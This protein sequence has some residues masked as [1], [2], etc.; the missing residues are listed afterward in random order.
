MTPGSN[1]TWN[2][3]GD[4][5]CRFS[6]FC[7]LLGKPFADWMMPIAILLLHQHKTIFVLLASTTHIKWLK[8]TPKCWSPIQ[9]RNEDITLDSSVDT[10]AVQFQWLESGT[11]R[12]HAF[13][14]NLPSFSLVPSQKYG[15]SASLPDSILSTNEG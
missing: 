3:V 13:G 12:Q 11:D 2:S 14:K 15:V 5:F 4:P 9:S 10:A 7:S 1:L 6:P 8:K